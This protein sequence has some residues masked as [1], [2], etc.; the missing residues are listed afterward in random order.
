MSELLPKPKGCPGRKRTVTAKAWI[1]RR[2]RGGEFLSN[3]S[4]GDGRVHVLTTSTRR[5]SRALSFNLAHLLSKL[6]P[7]PVNPSDPSDP[8]DQSDLFPSSTPESSQP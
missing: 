4:L 6:R 5:R 3:V 7:L 8:S 2:V 1:S